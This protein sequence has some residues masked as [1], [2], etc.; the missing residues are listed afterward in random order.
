MIFFL[1]YS[2]KMIDVQG[3]YVHYMS[4]CGCVIYMSV[5]VI[6]LLSL[7]KDVLL[8][9]LEYKCVFSFNILLLQ[10]IY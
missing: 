9:L 2:G 4:L 6:I 8:E 10:R 1:H 3:P 7:N 5:K